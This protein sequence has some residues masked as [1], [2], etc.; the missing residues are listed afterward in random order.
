MLCVSLH[1]YM[2]ILPIACEAAA[3]VDVDDVVLSTS[4]ASVSVFVCDQDQ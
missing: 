3:A 1:G 2:V 4:I